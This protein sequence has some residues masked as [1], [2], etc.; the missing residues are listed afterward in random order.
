MSN[1]DVSGE[2]TICDQCHTSDV[3]VPD[4]HQ[5]SRGDLNGHCKQC[6]YASVEPALKDI[7]TV[8]AVAIRDLMG[9]G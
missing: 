9:R 5:L 6:G 4:I 8:M 7:I 2:Y 3:V 1:I